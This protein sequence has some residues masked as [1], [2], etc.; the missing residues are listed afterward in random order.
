MDVGKA[1]KNKGCKDKIEKIGER[2]SG[3]KKKKIIQRL[4]HPDLP[5]IFTNSPLCLFH[6]FRYKVD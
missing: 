6:I 5:L 4:F 3:L 1:H 2:G